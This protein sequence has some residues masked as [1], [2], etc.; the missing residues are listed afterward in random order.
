MALV[1]KSRW[2]WNWT[3]PMLVAVRFTPSCPR[4]ADVP[5][6]VSQGNTAPFQ[7]PRGTE[8]ETASTSGNNTGAAGLPFHDVE[9]V[10]S[11]TFLTVRLAKAIT[12]GDSR[13]GF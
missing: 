3:G 8:S 5:E 9:T 4:P 13:D 10:P 7:A 11:G 2:T 12:P 1:T 6:G